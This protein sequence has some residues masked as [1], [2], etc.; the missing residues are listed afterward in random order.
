MVQNNSE[1]RERSSRVVGAAATLLFHLLL[2]T[3]CVKSAVRTRYS[4]PEEISLLFDFSREEVT[5]IEVE[6]GN[7]PKAENAK[8]ENEVRLAQRSQAQVVSETPSVGKESTMEGEGDA[9]Q[10]EPE[11]VEIDTRALFGS[12][13]NRSDTLAAQT[14]AKVSD[15]LKAGTP[16]GNTRYGDIDN[17]PMA[18]LKGRNVMGSLPIP[19]YDTDKEGRVVV[20]ILVDQYGKVTNAVP[21]AQGT[22]VQ[23]KVLWEAAKKAAYKALFNVNASAPAIQ[24]GTITYIFKLK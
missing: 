5:P 1:K 24:Q 4:P 7:L 23:D 15:A 16:Q 21:G 19:E 3:L 12:A 10:Y 22:T 20:R 2:L 8:P 6:A 14:A 17:T 11:R 13:N 18:N 9:M